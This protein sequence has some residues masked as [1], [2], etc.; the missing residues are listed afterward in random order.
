MLIHDFILDDTGD[1]PLFAA[2]FSLNMLSGTP[3]GRS[4]AQQELVDMMT[5]AGLSNIQRIPYHGP[6]DSGVISAKKQ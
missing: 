5:Q 4:Y 1:G 2:L 3:E 6:T